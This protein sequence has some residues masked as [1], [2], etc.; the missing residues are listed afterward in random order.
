VEPPRPSP[1]DLRAAERRRE[2][3]RERAQERAEEAARERTEQR[4][5][6]LARDA[7]RRAAEQRRQTA[8]AAAAPGAGSTAAAPARGS[9]QGGGGARQSVGNV[10]SGAYAAQVRAILQARANALG[11]EDVEG[12]VGISFSVGPSGRLM[13]H[14]IS[15]PSGNFTID[16]AIRSM[17][18]SVAFPPPPGGSFSGNVTVRV[19]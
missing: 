16:R 2:I 13:S 15:R 9:P 10:S 11:L 12:V 4:R 3:E 5:A 14:G 1:Q 17:L 19:R 6:A 7:E 8:S 18:A